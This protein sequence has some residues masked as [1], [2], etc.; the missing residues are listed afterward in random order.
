MSAKS[1]F[2]IRLAIIVAFSAGALLAHSLLLFRLQGETCI[3]DAYISF[4]YA[5]NLSLGHG[6]VLNL[7]ERVEGYTNFLWVVLMASVHRLGFDVPLAARFLSL[8][9]GLVLIVYALLFLA[10]GRRSR[11]AL[12]AAMVAGGVLSVDGS[13]ARWSQDG[14]ETILF[15]LLTLASVCRSVREHEA[16]N[17]YPLSSLYFAFAT[18][19]RPEGFLLFAASLCFRLSVP[20]SERMRLRRLAHII[21]WYCAVVIPYLAWRWLYYGDLLPNTFYAKVGATAHQILR[22]VDY[23]YAFAVEQHWPLL[24]L[25]VLALLAKSGRRLSIWHLHLLSVVVVY[26]VYVMLVG[27]DW[28]GSGRF[29]VP[30]L[31]LA[32]IVVADMFS[33]AIASGDSSQHKMAA[34]VSTLF[35]LGMLN[36]ASGWNAEWAGVSRARLFHQSRLAVAHWLREHAHPGDTL[37]T[38]EIGLFAYYSGLYVADLHGLTDARIAHSIPASSMGQGKA[39]HEKFDLVY[40]FSKEP[41]W[42]CTAGLIEIY[43]EE[44]APVPPL[45]DYE[46]VVIDIPLPFEYYRYIL[47]R[48]GAD[49]VKPVKYVAEME[50]HSVLVEGAGANR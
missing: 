17:K 33:A 22:G 12:P 36:Y 32:V 49:T 48:R 3:D 29:I 21:G 50:G 42:I 34:I 23:V 14:M 16:P 30:V 4:A 8:A 10:L 41:T 44:R 20:A 6:L 9:L 35:C 2:R 43:F 1:S 27:G 5:R 40:S 11:S 31:P 19:T 37:L 28:M 47:H 13:L 39:G 38:N 45:A 25:F 24:A 26:L 46:A 7:G 15:S 18:L